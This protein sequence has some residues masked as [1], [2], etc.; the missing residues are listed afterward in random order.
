MDKKDKQDHIQAKAYF[1]KAIEIDPQYPDPYFNRGR[2]NAK[3]NHDDEAIE[4]YNK[5]IELATKSGGQDAPVY[6]AYFEIGLI[7]RKRARKT[8]KKEY[9]IQAETYFCSAIKNLVSRHESDWPK[10]TPV[11]FYRA[12]EAIFEQGGRKNK[13]RS[14][15][16]LHDGCIWEKRHATG[17]NMRCC[18]NEDMVRA[19]LGL[20]PTVDW[21]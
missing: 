3:L 21:D 20:K 1:N 2:A 8:G 15:K 7:A 6:D 11:Y 17:G 12:S 10:E 14:L 16:Y 5:Y 4:N 13:M 19:K 18:R 9:W